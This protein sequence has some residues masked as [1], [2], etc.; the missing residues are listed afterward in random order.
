[1]E[2][3]ISNLLTRFEK[4]SLCRRE[5]VQGFAMPAAGGTAATAQED[6]D[7]S[8]HDMAGTRPMADRQAVVPRAR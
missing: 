4:G 7:F 6:V 2:S 5:L 1:M 3:I 8:C